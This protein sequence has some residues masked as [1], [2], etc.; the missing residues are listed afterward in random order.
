MYLFFEL[1]RLRKVGTRYHIQSAIT[2]LRGTGDALMQ[3][4]ILKDKSLLTSDGSRIA[5]N[6][7][8]C[9]LA[10]AQ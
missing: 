10:L 8:D 2:C 3:F 7:V 6:S 1:I 5:L 4:Y 9:Q